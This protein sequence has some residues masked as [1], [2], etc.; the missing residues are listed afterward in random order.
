MKLLSQILQNNNCDYLAMRRVI[1]L[2][3]FF[4]IGMIAFA[5]FATINLLLT[6]DYLVSLL[7]LALFI[8]FLLLYIDLNK[9]KNLQRASIIGTFIIAVFMLLFVYL[10]HNAGF[11][12]I[13]TIFVPVF[14]VALFGSKQGMFISFVYYLLLFSLLFYGLHHWKEPTWDLLSF[15]RFVFASLVLLWVLYVTESS[16]EK[17]SAILEKMT[18]TDALTELYNRRKIDE[19]MEEK[20][21]EYERYGTPLS[22]AIL[23]IDDFKEI[24]DTHGHDIGDKVLSELSSLLKA[25]SRKSDIIARWG[26]EEFMFIMQNTQKK[27]A[28]E[29]MEKLREVIA[30]HSF[31]TIG[32]ITCSIGVCELT[33]DISSANKLFSCADQAL[34]RSKNNGKNS[35]SY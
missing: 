24:N 5:S 2:N 9:K 35:V 13:W 19:I 15:L 30:K 4:I 12:L 29:S 27:N 28:I 34:Y 21:Y 18:Y 26:G 23:D 6:Q 25:N 33:P 11:G 7:D 8:I 22:I 17:V 3:S 14:G 31:E 1:I 32:H 20:C 10:N 16:F